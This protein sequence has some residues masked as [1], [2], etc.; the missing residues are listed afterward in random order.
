MNE[1]NP[2]DP[3]AS[4]HSEPES[5]SDISPGRHHTP[6]MLDYLRGT[7]PWTLF[8]AILTYVGAGFAAIGG[9]AVM[10]AAVVASSSTG[11]GKSETAIVV[12]VGVM[13]FVAAALGFWWA[14][15]LIKYAQ[16]IGRAVESDRTAD[17]EHALLRQK[18]F[19][20]ANGI[21]AIVYIGVMVVAL[22]VF[23]IAA[24]AGAVR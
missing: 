16:A 11:S 22:F 4:L 8:M 23:T 24:M 12:G 5:E 6:R 2:Y 13:Y 7:R 9:L 3:P 1:F 21:L 15:M 10:V 19:W 17:V 20:K 18:T 14:T